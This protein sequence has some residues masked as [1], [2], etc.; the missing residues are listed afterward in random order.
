MW[1]KHQYLEI[2]ARFATKTKC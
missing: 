2:A 1:L